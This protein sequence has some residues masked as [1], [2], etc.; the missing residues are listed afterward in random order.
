M[1]SVMKTLV[2]A[3]SNQHKIGELRKICPD[4]EILGLQDLGF[5][6]EIEETGLTL[7]ENA[8]LKAEF[9]FNKI[10]RPV[11]SEDTGLEVEALDGAPGVH[12]A[13]YAGEHRD[14]DANMAKLL[15]AL[16]NVTNRKAAFRTIIALRH[17]GGSDLFE[18]IVCGNI[19]LERSGFQ[20]FGYDPVFIPEG[21]DNTFAEL[22]ASVKNQIS[23]R[24]R[25]VQKVIGF[26]NENPL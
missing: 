21:H 26:L 3:T 2:F 20:G 14:P 10:G 7:E 19:A 22:P 5:D 17:H 6:V 24:A 18:G 9:L 4:Y 1:N 12:T 25:A 8:L 15:N 23:H 16:T 13:R 11:L